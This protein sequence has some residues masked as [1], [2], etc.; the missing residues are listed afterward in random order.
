MLKLGVGGYVL[1]LIAI[2]W[3]TLSICTCIPVRM[4][5]PSE[6]VHSALEQDIYEVGAILLDAWGMQYPIIR[7]EIFLTNIRHI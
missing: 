4:C 7:C 6:D 5:E 1:S 2:C 3:S